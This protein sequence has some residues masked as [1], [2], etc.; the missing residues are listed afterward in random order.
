MCEID[1]L[2]VFKISE[3]IFT[4]ASLAVITIYIAY[5]QL[6]TNRLKLKIDLYDRRLKVY[7]EARHF[8]KTV[9]NGIASSED[10]LTFEK[11]I[12]NSDFLFEPDI[13]DYLEQI[14]K[15]GRQLIFWD[16]QYGY[17]NSQLKPPG[18]NIDEVLL[19]K[20]TESDWIFAQRELSKQRFK[21]YLAFHD[22]WDIRIEHSVRRF[23]RR[24]F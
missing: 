15:H 19:H 20:R 18:Y 2:L 16:E 5:Q 13:K 3:S 10:L 9:Q 24:L 12:F 22:S 17:C 21:K 23:F 14:Y 1:W 6:K 8:I 4:P 11:A 7:E